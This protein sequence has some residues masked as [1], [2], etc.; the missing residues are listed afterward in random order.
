M[1]QSLLEGYV[2][3]RENNELIIILPGIYLKIMNLFLGSFLFAGIH[4]R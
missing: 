4:E 3:Q 1:F 2:K